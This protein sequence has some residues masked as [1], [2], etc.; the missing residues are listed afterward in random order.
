MNTSTITELLI[1]ILFGAACCTHNTDCAS[2]CNVS[3]SVI[4]CHKSVPRR[5]YLKIYCILALYKSNCNL[6]HHLYYEY[7]RLHQIWI[8][9]RSSVTVDIFI[10]NCLMMVPFGLTHVAGNKFQSVKY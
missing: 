3:V 6:R 2:C 10:Y 7:D 4:K 5:I 1:W 8:H 9:I